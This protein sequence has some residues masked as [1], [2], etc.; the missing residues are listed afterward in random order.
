MITGFS[1]LLMPLLK[2]YLLIVS[3][4]FTHVLFAQDYSF[5]RYDLK[6][7]L[8]GSTVYTMTQDKDGFLWFGTET[9]LSR[10]DGT[11]FM[12]LSTENGLPDNEILT[13][14]GDKKGR[15]W[16]APFKVSICY[17]YNG[18]IHTNE[19][20]SLLAQIH[21]KGNVYRIAEDDSGN[22]LL[23]ENNALHLI[24]SS[25]KVRTID[26][27]YGN[28]GRFN[29]IGPRAGG[30]F[31]VFFR[32]SLYD[33][34]NDVF[35][36]K[37]Y[38]GQISEH[39]AF[40]L[41]SKTCYAYRSKIYEMSIVRLKDNAVLRLPFNLEVLKMVSLNDSLISICRKTGSWIYNINTFKLHAVYLKENTHGFAMID[42]ER[43][44]WFCTL[45]QGVF[46]LNSDFIYN[47]TIRNDEKRMLGVTSV[48]KSD[49]G[50]YLGTDFGRLYEFNFKNNTPV[51]RHVFLDQSFDDSS[52]L[53]GL[54]Y[55][56][57]FGIFCGT[58]AMYRLF[59]INGNLKTS[60]DKIAVK[61]VVD[62]GE[63]N[64]VATSSYVL[65]VNKLDFSKRD[66]IWSNRA[67]CI[68]KFRDS[69]FI[70][71]L[72]G[73]YLYRA[74]KSVVDMGKKYAVFKNR[75]SF[76]TASSNGTVWVA[77]FGGGI[78]A[79][80]N[81]KLIRVITQNHG[82]PSNV[83]KTLLA[84]KDHLWVGTDKG[85]A[86]VD[87]IGD[88][89]IIRKY[90]EADGLLSDNINVIHEFNGNVFFGT[91]KGLSYFLNDENN[92]ESTCDLNMVSFLSNGVRYLTE[93]ITYFKHDQNN[94]QFEFV[95]ISFRSIGDIVYEYRLI[96][97]D[98]T[99][100]KTRQNILNYPAL[101]S[102]NYEFEI[103][104]T[105]KFGKRSETRRV[106]FTIEQ[107][108]QERIWFRVLLICVLL[109]SIFMISLFFIKRNK[110]KEQEK[111]AIVKKISELE[112]LAIKSQMN[113]HF[114]FNSLNSI[115]QYVMDK[116]VAGANKF[117]SGFSRLIRQTLDF[118][119]KQ[120]V[121]IQEE[122]DYLKNYL[123]LEKTRLESAFYYSIEVDPLLANS[124]Y[125]IPP[126]IL[127]P[128]VENSVR[129]GVRYRKDN[130][131]HIRIRVTI[132]E[133][134]IYFV[135]EDNGVGR[136]Q[137][138]NFK[139]SIPIEYQ[140]KGMSLTANRVELLNN[141]SKQKM[142]VTIED[143]FPDDKEYPGTRVIV[144]MPAYFD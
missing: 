137:S 140:S 38:L 83:C 35:S 59:D 94:I 121:G 67:T 12:N 66:T 129:H 23:Q 77:T 115:Q 84:E 34:K 53:I 4:F 124:G 82:L 139:S 108:L 1:V 107:I 109:V 22:I 93:G 57:G 14:F 92:F 133:N 16:I 5:T 13:L 27:V 86:K 78:A 85:A 102:G 117:I 130:S 68:Y 87:I 62:D 119:S 39:M 80:K 99:W 11:H 43:N 20:D 46:K 48:V 89:L 56:K 105:N 18:K 70:G 71:S 30:G 28:K 110:N 144:S 134:H 33:F 63:A 40:S 24:D 122:L 36:G 104:A 100:N 131:G 143:A 41:F 75:V 98:T 25:G 42:K 120:K 141:S 58:G 9:G 106:L 15:I 138:K 118:S 61:Q 26:N 55:E 112:Q 103:V 32:D 65:R 90:S 37:A 44:W 126:M 52:P 8:A 2:R 123:E 96:G 142:Q 116:D 128:F 97:S 69:L 45:G 3:L 127:Q 111:T 7:G 49:Y 79:L 135:I 125:S 51:V 47:V 6:D 101:P 136:S 10:F 91:S 29:N 50:F 21:L 74:D 54:G 114:I 88:S 17:Y 81:G 64:Y 72:N 95:A 19:N 132:D 76:I 113:P 31:S 73:L 60:I